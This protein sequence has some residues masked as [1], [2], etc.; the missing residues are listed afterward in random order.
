MDIFGAAS[1]EGAL[2]VVVTT[3]DCAGAA[4]LGRIADFGCCA[5]SAGELTDSVAK[6]RV[7]TGIRNSRLQNVRRTFVNFMVLAFSL[8]FLSAR[9]VSRVTNC[10]SARYWT[11]GL[12]FRTLWIREFENQFAESFSAAHG[13]ISAIKLDKQTQDVLFNYLSPD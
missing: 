6:Q 13:V 7:L 9:N 12:Y 3:C 10:P 4:A 8:R 5:Q 11:L 1:W 2:V